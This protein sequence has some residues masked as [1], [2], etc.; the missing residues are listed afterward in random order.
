M[1]HAEDAMVRA[2]VIVLIAAAQLVASTAAR[3]FGTGDRVLL[4]SLGTIPGSRWLD[5][6]TVQ[7]TVGLAPSFGAP[8][9]GTLWELTKVGD[10]VFLLKTLGDLEGFRWLDGQTSD[11]TVALAP[12]T[13][14]PF[15]GTRWEFFEVAPGEY[16]LRCL[17][18]IE[19]RRWLDARTADGTVGLAPT[20]ADPF[21]GTR[22]RVHLQRS[23]QVL[24]QHNDNARTGANLNET[25]LDPRLLRAGRFG[26]LF[27]RVVDGQIY[28]Q[29]L[30]VSDLVLPGKGRHNVVFVATTMNY[31]YAFD[32]EDPAQQA[33]LWRSRQLGTPVARANIDPGL[34]PLIDPTIGITS[35]PVVD[36]ATGTM[37]VVAKSKTLEPIDSL[38]EVKD[39]DRVLLECRGAEPGRRWLDGVTADQ[40]VRL[41]GSPDSAFTGTIWQVTRSG[42]LVTL[43]TL[44]DQRDAPARFLDGR[45]RDSTVGLAPD[46][47]PPFTGTSWRLHQLATNEFAFENRGDFPSPR[48]WLDGQTVTGSVSL[49]PS[50]GGVFTGT[51][52]RIHRLVMHHR[53]YALDIATGQVKLHRPPG[54]HEQIVEIEGRSSL[55]TFRPERHLNRPGLLLADNTI[56][57]AFGAQAD[58]PPWQGWV[59]AYDATTLQPFDP[60]LVRP[61]GDGG[62]I[63]QAGN[64]LV[65]DDGGF[66]Y[67]MTGNRSFFDLGPA[68][69]DERNSFVKLRR[70]GNALVSDGHFTPDNRETL[71]DPCDVD[72]GSAGPVLLPGTHRLAGAGKEGKL[73]LIDTASMGSALQILQVAV[74][75]FGEH[76]LDCPLPAT[77]QNRNERLLV[78]RTYP[79]VHGSPVV[80][81]LAPPSR[82][83]LYLW[84]EQDVLKALTY[85]QDRFAF[86]PIQAAVPAPQD[87]MPGGVLSLSAD[88][89]LPGSGV[90]W[91]TRPLDCARGEPTGPENE[92]ARSCN[93]EEHPAPGGLFAYDASTLE[94]LWDTSGA[95]RDRLGNLGKFAPPTLACGRVYVATFP[96]QSDCTIDACPSRLVVYGIPPGR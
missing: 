11:G 53:L 29:P 82:E 88:G 94:A 37:Y 96:R 3:A 55:V 45:T 74:N 27:D 2:S 42:D 23:V 38:D 63:W 78:V 40:S 35:T 31:V 61:T 9:T 32:A 52:W 68:P 59:F 1:R 22:W 62:G 21:S 7:H 86:A 28:A 73:F 30:Y 25:V 95:D 66:V 15:S 77:N 71:L 65:G 49:A 56:Y 10:H 64:G 41:Q 79:H 87:S 14:P 47:R 26:Y 18:V 76:P 60:Y 58:A 57:V 12:S 83:M 6:R 4:E 54:R 85:E 16:T 70:A 89:V 81:P 36:L 17:G 24:T 43:M 19:G 90:V 51:H 8:F 20:T 50:T 5:G 48:I 72:L 13:D 44:G 84:A 46:A 34:P 92:V 93:A 33:P 75:G 67:F 91:G 39:A 69:D 80:W